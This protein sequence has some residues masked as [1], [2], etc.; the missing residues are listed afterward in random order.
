MEK[1]INPEDCGVLYN[2]NE[3]G[4]PDDP[5]LIYPINR[6]NNEGNEK[7]FKLLGVLFDEYL[8]FEYHISSL[9]AKVS[10]SLFCINRIKNF[11]T[12][13]SL[14]ML[15]FS[16]VHSHIVYCINIYSCANKT[17]LNK[18]Q[19][20]QKE[21]IRMISSAGYRDH[22]K[23]LFKS[24]NILPL[25]ELI[26]FSTLKFMHSFTNKKLPMIFNDLWSTNAVINPNR[27]LRNANH[28]K[29]PSHHFASVR[30]FP[31]FTFPRLWNEEPERKSIPNASAYLRILKSSLLLSL[32][33]FI[34]ILLLL[35]V[36][37]GEKEGGLKIG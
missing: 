18:L 22:T 29:V 37:S 23:P 11:V 10:K 27:E 14:K 34:C 2:S 20:K 15:Y 25:D 36:V 12:K 13:P 5:S 28:L 24:V 17:N 31:L 21:A 33:Y 32:V 1:K 9:C 16:M 30:R 8:S 19:I 3:I 7:S 4:H 6:I 26:Q 35:K